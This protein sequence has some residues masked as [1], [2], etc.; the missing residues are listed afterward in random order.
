MGRDVLELLQGAEQVHDRRRPSMARPE[1][2]WRREIE[3]SSFMT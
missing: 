1:T 2:L 3:R